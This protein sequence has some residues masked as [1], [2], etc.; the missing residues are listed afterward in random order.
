MKSFSIKKL[1]LLLSMLIFIL[2]CFRIMWIMY[3]QPSHEVQASD[4]V[5]DLSEIN[6]APSETVSLDGEWDFYPNRLLSPTFISDDNNLK[7]TSMMVPGT[8]ILNSENKD[9]IHYGTYHLKIILPK[10][11]EEQELYGL[12]IKDI[13]SAYRVYAHDDLIL[14]TGIPSREEASYKSKP[15]TYKA[16]VSTSSNEVDLLIQVANFENFQPGGIPFSIDFGLNKTINNQIYFSRILQTSIVVLLI[17]HS[18]YALSLYII[19][20]QTT[21]KELLFFGLLLVFGALSILVDEDKLLIQPFTIDSAL[22]YQLLYFSFAGVLFFMLQFVKHVFLINSV[23][24][25][26]LF[27]LYPLSVIALFILP[28]G[29]LPYVGYT[30]MLLN[31]VSYTSITVV[32]IK[33]LKKGN[34]DAFYILIANIVNFFNVLWGVAINLNLFDIPYYPVDFLVGILAIGGLLLS[35][36][37]RTV[38][39]NE[40]QKAELLRADK[41]K[42][43][44]LAN[45]SHELR[46]PLHGIITIAQSILHNKSEQLSEEN[47]SYLSLLVRIGKQMKFTLNDLLDMSKLKD[48]HVE[49]NKQ[50]TNLSSV[51]SGVIDIVSFMTDGK[52][53]EIIN[54]IE[55]NFPLVMADKNRLTQIVFNLLHNAVKYTEEGNITITATS[56]KTWATITISDTGIGISDEEQAAIFNPYLQGSDI[57]N[58]KEEGI[59]LGLSISKQ[60]IELHGGTI[61]VTSVLEKGSSF[62][63]TL[64]LAKN[65]AM[66]EDVKEEVAA[67]VENTSIL[68]APRTKET[69][70]HATSN[71]LI[72]DDDPVNLKILCKL[73]DENYHLGTARNGEEALNRLTDKQWD[74][75]ISDV[76]MP[77]MSGYQLTREIRKQYTVSELPILLLTARNQTEDI[78]T[79]FDA[80][81]NDYIAKPVDRVE[82]LS[83]VKSLIDLKV[84]IHEHLRM[85]AALLQ[86]QI[87]PHFLF[88]TLNTIASLSEVD[89]TRMTKLLNQFGNYLRRSFDIKNVDTLISLQEEL[90]IVKSYVYIETERFGERLA[91]EWDIENVTDIRIPPLTIQPLVE[92]AIQHG[93]LP[94]PIGG[95]VYITVAVHSNHAIVSVADDGLG[96][97]QN[98]VDQLLQKSSNPPRG[99]GM[100]NTNLRLKKL[101]GEGLQ[102]ESK[103]NEGT[104]IQFTIPLNK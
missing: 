88:N 50:P 5:L 36:Y 63:F 6:L 95:C 87:R 101:F 75:I 93:I 104:L 17:L 28:E 103:I 34:K 42:D 27:I 21:K 41:K 55:N 89:T 45:T 72:V 31:V 23:M 49:L 98:V 20:R 8:W 39:L 56:T 16:T 24:F 12:R 97:E 65:T 70:T 33:L 38:Q 7:Q 99:I 26:S 90:E 66:N 78:H 73:L 29:S 15:G 92:N 14:E 35:R 4:G 2:T 9:N 83:R 62:T 86:A 64:P 11:L 44:F 1:I 32:V 67:V 61:R 71:V 10:E 13:S 82:L 43:E 47:R 3:Y 54:E 25:R 69:T 79:A 102:I 84:S 96:M 59:G 22:A 53:L 37:N 77:N 48:K 40:L 58:Y 81:A 94:R 60:L 85:E 52:K 57:R 80:G 74:L 76:M 18:I 100:A 19:S 68:Q 91:V 51:S 30:I 46:N